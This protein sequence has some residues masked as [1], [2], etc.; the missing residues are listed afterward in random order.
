MVLP[1]FSRVDSKLPWPDQRWPSSVSFYSTPRAWPPRSVARSGPA[2][3]GVLGPVLGSPGAV[4]CRDGDLGEAARRCRDGLD[5]TTR[6]DRGIVI[7]HDVVGDVMH[8][9]HAS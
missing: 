6:T 2:D 1:L 9:D 4:S 5:R 7:I 3:P 8:A